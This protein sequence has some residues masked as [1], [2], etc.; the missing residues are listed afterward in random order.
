MLRDGQQEAS[1]LDKG[2]APSVVSSFICACGFE[3]VSESRVACEFIILVGISSHCTCYLSNHIAWLPYCVVE[4]GL[5]W[6]FNVL[7]YYAAFDQLT[8]PL[9]PSAH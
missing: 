9:M 6:E 3:N 1:T 2:A 8:E 4:R 7:S 5:S